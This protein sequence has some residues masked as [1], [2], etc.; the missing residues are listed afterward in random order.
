VGYYD[1]RT[2][3]TKDAHFHVVGSGNLLAMLIARR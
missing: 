3:V 1:P 2:D